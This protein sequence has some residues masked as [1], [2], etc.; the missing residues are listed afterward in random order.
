MVLG[1]KALNSIRGK[2]IAKHSEGLVP[3][4]APSFAENQ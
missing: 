4:F 2:V 1:D 3:L